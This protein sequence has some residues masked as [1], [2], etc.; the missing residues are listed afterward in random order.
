M[1]IVLEKLSTERVELLP[2]VSVFSPNTVNARCSKASCR[3]PPP[4]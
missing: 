3:Y 1:I 4:F 2:T